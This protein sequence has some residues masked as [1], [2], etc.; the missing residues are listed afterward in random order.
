MADTEQLE[1]LKRSVTEWN[2]WRQEH[3]HRQPD[4]SRADLSRANLT[5][6]NLSLANLTEANLTLANLSRANLFWANLSRARL[7]M[8]DLTEAH[9]LRAHLTR[10][11]LT[12]TT[13]TLANLYWADLSEADLSRTNFT[14]TYFWNTFFVQVD[15]SQVLGLEA[16]IYNGPS[17]VN[18]NSVV[19]P[20]NEQTRIQFLRGVG[21]SDTFI[22]YLPSLLT[23]PVQYSSVFLS[24]SQHDEAFTKRL[25][26]DLQDQGVRCWF[27]PHDLRPG[28][29]IRQG[30]D[31]AIHRQDKLLLIL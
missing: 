6:A 5:E 20:H 7:E 26:N 3:P 17:T 9:L 23:S 19:L 28:E 8:A 24:Y 14:R 13:F 21:F 27:A 18:I 16:A 2:L 10:A 25:H 4:L 1:R 15:L 11:N 30:I 12:S 29:L 31:E 22:E